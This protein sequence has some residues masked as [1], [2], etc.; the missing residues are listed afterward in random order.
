MANTVHYGLSSFYYALK[1]SSGYGTKR[2][3]PGAVKI[4]LTP[5]EYTLSF[6]GLDCIPR[7]VETIIY[8]YKGTLEI[9]ALPQI[10]YQE[11][12]GYSGSTE[13][14]GVKAN[15]CAIYFQTDGNPIENHC[16][17]LCTFG[18][19]TINAETKTDTTNVATLSVPLTIRADSSGNIKSVT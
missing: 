19:P 18:R 15:P 8:G 9:A 13:K 10:F 5:E 16:Y 6:T 7:D 2:A 17:Y 11:I 14:A 12:Y 1:T 3:L 4:N